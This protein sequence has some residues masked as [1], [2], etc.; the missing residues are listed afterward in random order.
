MW[1]EKPGNQSHLGITTHHST[2]HK[3]RTSPL[4]VV[5]MIPKQVSCVF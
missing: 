3:N 4:K 2:P 1:W 5:S